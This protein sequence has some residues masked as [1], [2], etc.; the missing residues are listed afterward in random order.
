M[1]KFP[2]PEILFFLHPAR[3]SASSMLMSSGK[4]GHLLSLWSHEPTVADNV[5]DWH[6]DPERAAQFCPLPTDMHPALGAYLHQSGIAQL[7]THQVA[8]WRAARE[9]SNLVVVTGTASG[10]TLCYTLPVLDQTLRDAHARALFLFPTK[11]LTQDQYQG[12]TTAARSLAGDDRPALPVAIYDGD[13]PTADRPAIRSTARLLLSNPDMLHTGILPHHTRWAEF[14]RGLRCVVIDEMHVY[15]GVFGSHIANLLRRLKRVAAFYGSYPQFFLTSATIGNPG[16]LAESLIELPVTV[17]DQDGSPRGKRHFLLYNP[18]ITNPDLGIRAS[19]MNESIR[20]TSDLLDLNVQTL[21]F[22]KAR[23][24]VEM[25][26]KYLQQTRAEDANAMRSYRSGYLA[27]ERRAIEHSLREGTARAVVATN[28]LELGI[29]IGSMDAVILV[30]YPGSIASTRQQAGRAGRKHGASLAVL[31]ASANPLDQFLMRHTQF[32]F[33]RS[34]EQ[35][36]INPDNLLIVLQHIRCAAF[37]LPF[38]KGEKFGRLAAE[39]LSALLDL[40]CQSG[41]LHTSA[42]QYFW[43][44]DRYPAEN[45][46]LRSSSPRQVVLHLQTQGSPVA[47]GK[48]DYESALW[49]VHPQAIYLHSGQTYAVETLDLENNTASLKPTSVDYYT[50]PLKQV[51][52]ER[53]TLARHSVVPGGTRSFGELMVTT[54]VTGFRRLR[55]YSNEILDETELT[56]PATQLRTTGYWMTFSQEEL[57]P[58]RAAGLWNNDPNQYGPTWPYLRKLILQRDHHTCQSCG[59]PESDQ[60]LH[61]HHKIPLRSFPSYTQ[62]NNPENLISLCPACHRRAEQSVMIR[63]GLAGLAYVLHNLAPLFLMCDVN[64]LGAQSDP[65]SPLAEKQPAVVLYDLVPGGI[66]LSD[67]IYDL[68]ET[69]MQRAYELVSQCTCPNGCPSCVGPAA[70]NGIGGKV[71]TLAL[72]SVLCGLPP[73]Q[74]Q[75]SI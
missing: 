24:S 22:C 67:A 37:E 47:I 71:E 59:A 13:T 14:F 58:L 69:L 40:L 4:T 27:A 41:D 28:A 25:M 53:L 46:S 3:E 65:L 49:M 11:A 75:A 55:W 45:V 62:A 20:L 64:D 5:V 31:V 6:T 70:V 12:L 48:L 56:L 1:R 35:A 39:L 73:S 38:R 21:L 60:P 51:E 29:D 54:Q 57:A 43:M 68:H 16:A 34:P 44:A 30:G 9:G 2:H 50:D 32:L 63:S 18:P 52:I 17:I 42:D 72:L 15:R 61:V 10:K 19:A 7:Y 26:L 8:A 74:A 36:R 23:R 66:G 33:E